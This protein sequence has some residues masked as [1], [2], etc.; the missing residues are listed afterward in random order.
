[1]Q[2]QVPSL[3]QGVKDTGLLVGAFGPVDMASLLSGASPP[4]PH[5]DAILVDG[6]LSYIEHSMRGLV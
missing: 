6:V 3:I 4:I 5:V 2:V 1:M